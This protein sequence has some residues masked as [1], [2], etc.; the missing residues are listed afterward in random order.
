MPTTLASLLIRRLWYDVRDEADELRKLGSQR[1]VEKRL[2]QRRLQGDVNLEQAEAHIVPPIHSTA[3]HA[4]VLDHAQVGRRLL[5]L[6]HAA[7]AAAATGGERNDGGER[8]GDL[9]IV[10]LQH[11][12]VCAC[13]YVCTCVVCTCVCM[14]TC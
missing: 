12:C 10:D 5:L 14:E 2:Q 1:E 9:L 3:L 11:A 7:A 8:G 13:V 4:Q 6:C